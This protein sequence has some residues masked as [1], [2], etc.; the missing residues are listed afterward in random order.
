MATIS[1]S[2]DLEEPIPSQQR[3]VLRS[4]DWSTYRKI[5]DALAGRHLRLTFDGENLE[6]M[7]ISSEHGNC[8]RL[9]ARIIA[10]LTEE[11]EMPVKS[12]G[13]MTCDREDL[14]RGLEPDE[15][16]Y[17]AHERLIRN[18]DKIDLETDPPPDLAVEVDISRSSRNRMGIYAQLGVPEVWKYDGVSLC[19]FRL[20]EDGSY[21]P[22]IYSPSIPGVTA[23]ELEGFLRRRNQVDETSLVREFR[24]WLRGKKFSL[25]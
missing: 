24:D 22:T 23:V 12:V 11:F 8:S 4:V 14:E 7:T 25:S 16:F 18:K 21:V 19:F 17:L 3:F 9:M 6:F 10:V 13:D 15:C 20:T 5:S 1:P 2:P